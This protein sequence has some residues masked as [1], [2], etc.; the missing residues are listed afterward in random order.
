MSSD[1]AIEEA[2][3]KCGH[4]QL[5]G[6]ND[7]GRTHDGSF[8]SIEYL[9]GDALAL[10][11]NYCPD[12]NSIQNLASS[13]R[14]LRTAIFRQNLLHCDRCQ[15]PLFEDSLLSVATPHTQPVSCAICQAKLCGYQLF[16]YGRKNCKPQRCDGC[17][18]IECLACMESHVSDEFADGYGT[19]NYCGACQAEF[20]F[21]MG[22]C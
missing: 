14:L 11:V 15:I 16:D 19:E 1:I 18:A 20:E 13:S 10:I 21:G 7:D 17:G 5:S 2:H 3:Q 9:P 22:G 12:L 6:D 8:P 4:C